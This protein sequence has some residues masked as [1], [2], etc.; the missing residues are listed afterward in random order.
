MFL[1][2][3]VLLLLLAVKS[4]NART[5]KGMSKNLWP[6]PPGISHGAEWF[7]VTPFCRQ[8]IRRIF[9]IFIVGATAIAQVGMR[10]LMCND[11]IRKVEWSVS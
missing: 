3:L 9:R 10:K 11:V 5:S 6:P 8:S 7:V 1:L 4:L 2:S